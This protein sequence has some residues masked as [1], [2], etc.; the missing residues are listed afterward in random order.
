VA[1]GKR[2]AADVAIGERIGPRS[3]EL[4]RARLVRYAG[5]ALDFNAIHWS[6][7]AAE[8]AGLP[9]VI[10]HGMLTMALA[11][12]LVTDWAGDPGAVEDFSTRF[13]GMV[14]VGVEEP[15]T[16]VVEGAVTELLEGN[17]AVVELTVEAG[18][19][20]VLKAARAVVVLG[21]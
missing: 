15:A 10:A 19:T 6:D 13:S 14:P 5:A 9:D 11:G 16:V 12:R 4:D 21:P 1:E 17:R 2:S 3:F 7:L 18:G 8:R 20:G